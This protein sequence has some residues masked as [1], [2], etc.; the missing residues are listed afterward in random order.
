M[1]DDVMLIG[2]LLAGK[3]SVALYLSATLGLPNYP[4]DKLKWYYRLKNG[5]NLARGVH[6]RQSAGFGAH[7]EYARRFFSLSDLA[8]CLA[9]FR[10]GIIDFGASHSV[11]DDPEQ[12][13]A[14]KAILSLFRNVMLVM[15][16]P[17]INEAA[18][19][20]GERIRNRYRFSD[21]SDAII[22][23]YVEMNRRFIVS[24]SN[25]CLA[26]Y[27]IYTREKTVE[28]VG[29]EIASLAGYESRSPRRAA[30]RTAWGGC[31][32]SN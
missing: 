6:I 12:L 21:L 13:A 28:D 7:L 8:D 10:G 4:L 32:G 5:Y 16:S 23:S 27:C 26:R 25:R 19:I 30:E 9:R 2:P 3:T 18:E 11:F 1:R 17:D 15:P 24:E 29:D 20:L 22:E 14:A 31:Q